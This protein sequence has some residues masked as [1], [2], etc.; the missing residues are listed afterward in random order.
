MRFPTA[1]ES[2]MGWKK[3]RESKGQIFIFC[4]FGFV[5]GTG[6][7]LASYLP[8]TAHLEHIKFAIILF[9]K[10][11]G[12]FLVVIY[13]GALIFFLISFFTNIWENI[14][15]YK[16]KKFKDKIAASTDQDDSDNN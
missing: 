12:A 11:F 2:S 1:A 10:I 7:Y 14:C 4:L 6:V 3:A 8:I 9:E 16:I 13:G 5:V 15:D